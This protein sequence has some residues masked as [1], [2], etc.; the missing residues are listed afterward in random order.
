M[1]S[2]PDVVVLD[3]LDAQDTSTLHVS[4]VTIAAVVA[5]DSQT[6]STSRGQN[7]RTRL[8]ELLDHL[9]ED[10]VLPFDLNAALN[11]GTAA[12]SSAHRFEDIALAAIARENDYTVATLNGSPF[13]DANV[14]WICPTAA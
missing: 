10:R 9:F 4:T 8:H 1:R 12:M 13:T 14:R 7:F 5:A 2:S 6:R 3:W 11:A